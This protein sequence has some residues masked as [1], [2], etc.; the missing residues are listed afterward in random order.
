VF[1]TGSEDKWRLFMRELNLIDRPKP[2]VRYELLVVQYQAG[3]N[4]TWQRSLDVSESS[5]KGDF[6]FLGGLSNIL[7]L[8]FDVVSQFGYLFSAK[9]SMEMGNSKAKVFADTTLNGLSGQEV[10]F[11]NTSTFRYR[12]TEIDETTGKTKLTGVTREI[13]S[14]LIIGLNGWVSGDGMVT[15]T[16][17]ATVSK[18]GSDT[19]SS[20]G[21]PPPTSE[22]VVSTQIR[23]ASGKPVII[24]G[25]LQKETT[26]SVKKVPLLADIPVLG[27]LF[28]DIVSSEEDT[29]FVLYV[30]PHITWGDA[31][32]AAEVAGMER[33]YQTY[34][35]D[36]VK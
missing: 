18:R 14:G 9:L 2:Q 12:E 25:L 11:Q 32:G 19:S 4:V 15:M 31:D 6:S 23:T 29:E 27:W 26:K 33:Y 34:V 3:N 1:F 36:F 17:S 13:T 28:K 21:D 20:T 22:R 35:R 16:V 24:G 5:D 7:S 10:K 30:V 8:K